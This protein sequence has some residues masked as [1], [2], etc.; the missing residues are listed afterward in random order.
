MDTPQAAEAA[1]AALNNW[2]PGPHARPM[3][4]K[5]A[6]NRT[7]LPGGPPHSRPP[8]MQ[9]FN[10]GFGPGPAGEHQTLQGVPA[11][12]KSSCRTKRFGNNQILA[13]LLASFST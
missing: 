5:I 1:V 2:Q 10:P 11:P 7:A 9:H 3:N 8:P 13:C 12:L 4:V 6:D